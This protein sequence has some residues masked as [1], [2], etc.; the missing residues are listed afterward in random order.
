MIQV[1]DLNSPMQARQIVLVV[2]DEPLLRLNAIDMIEEA[3][4]DVVEAADADAAIII[5]E[6]RTDICL[7]FTDIDMPGTLCGLKLAAAIRDRWPPI[8]VLVTSGKVV[9]SDLDLPR[10]SR[11]IPKPYQGAQVA[12]ILRQMAA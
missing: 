4:F 10:H 9:A 11:F 12:S 6:N 1:I 7:V 3:G 5:L 8:H 2:E